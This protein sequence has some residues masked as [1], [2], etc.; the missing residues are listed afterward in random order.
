MKS[1]T[2]LCL[3]AVSLLPG[4]TRPAPQMETTANLPAQKIGARDLIAVQVYDSPELS[5]SI[6]VGADGLIRLPMLKQKVK[7]EG[8]DA[9]RARS[10]CGQGARR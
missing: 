2:T 10:R 7:A 6:R 9:E 5:R 8:P 3:L 1:L 4:Q